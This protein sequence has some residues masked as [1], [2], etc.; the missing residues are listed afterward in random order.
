MFSKSKYDVM[1]KEE[2]KLSVAT[3]YYLLK[4]KRLTKRY[5]EDTMENR[6][7]FQSE[8]CE[9]GN[10][11]FPCFVMMSHIGYEN[12]K[13]LYGLDKEVLSESLKRQGLDEQRFE[14]NYEKIINR[15][16]KK[17][18]TAMV[19]EEIGIDITKIKDVEDLTSLM[20]DDPSDVVLDAMVDSG[21]V[22]SPDNL[23]LVTSM[24]SSN[25]SVSSLSSRQIDRLNEYHDKFMRER[26]Y[27]QITNEKVENNKVIKLASR[28]SKIKY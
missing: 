12:A 6:E 22:L 5:E 16:T 15:Y 2:A 24:C 8:M 10:K 9:I 20:Q 3:I 14:A 28:I 7:N 11:L 25:F 13:D 19:I 21:V 1:K 18:L 17:L 26:I 27:S 4:V 23:E